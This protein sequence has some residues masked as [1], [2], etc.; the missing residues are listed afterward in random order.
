MAVSIVMFLVPFGFRIP[1]NCF[2]LRRSRGM[3]LVCR[4]LPDHEIRLVHSVPLVV[5][6]PVLQVRLA[7]PPTGSATKYA[8]EVV[9]YLWS[10]YK[11]F[12]MNDDGPKIRDLAPEILARRLREVG[13]RLPGYVPAASRQLLA[14]FSWESRGSGLWSQDPLNSI[15]GSTTSM[16]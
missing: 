2:W 12:L 13:R 5:R 9:D 8:D 3:V 10:N 6:R 7:L 4:C 16:T 11:R 1:C 14:G 15:R